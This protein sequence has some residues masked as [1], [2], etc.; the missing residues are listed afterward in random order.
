MES[1]RPHSLSN[2]ASALSPRTGAIPESN[3]ELKQAASPPIKADQLQAPTARSPIQ[4]VLSLWQDEPVVIS[5][6]DKNSALALLERTRKGYHPTVDEMGAYRRVAKAS[7]DLPAVDTLAETVPVMTQIFARLDRDKSGFLAD[8][9]I[10]AARLNPSFK[11][12]EAVALTTLLKLNKSIQKL[13]FNEW[14]QQSG[15]HLKDLSALGRRAAKDEPSKWTLYVESYVFNQGIKLRQIDQRLFPQGVASIR[16]DHIQQGEYGTCT[17][18]AAAAAMAANPAGKQ[19]LF[20]MISE[21]SDGSFLVHFPGEKPVAVKRPT[22]AELIL[23][24]SSG[25]D[26]LWLSV[27]EKAF[28]KRME[29]QMQGKSEDEVEKA[30]NSG[31][32]LS[33]GIRLLT[34]NK[35]QDGTIP[36]TPLPQLRS[37]VTQTLAENRVLLV[38]LNPD[39]AQ[40]KDKALKEKTKRNEEIYADGLVGLHAYSVIGFDPATDTITLRN[41][42]N[43]TELLGRD[44]KAADGVDDGVF[45]VKLDVFQKLFSDIAW[46]TRDKA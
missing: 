43:H 36:G 8:S 19:A 27:L 37:F 45:S 21:K 16:P 40:A 6:A 14:K 17:I 22:D 32:Y 13:S 31:Y 10:K 28:V 29:G 34:G 35:A 9:E 3:P 12:R 4:A 5:A 44:G 2:A 23:H 15:T 42:W 24:A 30:V 41:P 25:Q 20:E 46:Q 11:G 39:S 26:G 1:L 33:E 38:T 18:L 7:Q